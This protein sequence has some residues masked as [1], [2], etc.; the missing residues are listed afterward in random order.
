MGEKY[1]RAINRMGRATPGVSRST[2]LG[3]VALESGHVP[4]R[5]LLN[6]RQAR[7]LRRLFARPKG[8]D[9]PEGIFTRLRAAA[10][11]A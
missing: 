8:E 7:F 5:A 11:S 1:Q 4:A 2:R 6:H 3:A 9:G 10:S